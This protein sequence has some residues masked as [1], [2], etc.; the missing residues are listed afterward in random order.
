MEHECKHLEDE[1]S[2]SRIAITWK[3]NANTWKMNDNT[4]KIMYTPGG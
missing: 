1:P 2:V 3:M 4:W